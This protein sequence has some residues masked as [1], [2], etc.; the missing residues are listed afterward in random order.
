M[1]KSE[2]KI[3]DKVTVK[4]RNL[5]YYS[6]IHLEPDEV[7]TVGAVDVPYVIHIKGNS[8]SFVCVDFIRDG[9][10]YRAGVDYKNLKR[11]K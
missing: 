8:I 10:E 2:V 6:S 7:G 3:G 11:V 9:K 1:K 5:V 4:E